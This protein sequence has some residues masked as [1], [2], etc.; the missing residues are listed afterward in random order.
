ML[1]T[2]A[3][4]ICGAIP[5]CKYL[6]R[7]AKKLYASGSPLDNALVDQWVNWACTTLMPNLDQVMLGV[8]GHEVY[9]SSWKEALKELKSNVKTID[10]ALERGKG[11]L[12]ADQMTL[13][14]VVLSI[15]LTQGFQT[16]LDKGYR[17][18]IKQATE[19][20]TKLYAKPEFVKVQGAITFCDKPLKPVTVP[21]AK[22]ESKEKKDN[23]KEAK[24]AAP[25]AQAKPDKPEKVKDNVESLPPTSFDLFNFKTLYVNHKDK[26]GAGVDTFYEM[27]DW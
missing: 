25:A 19:W 23:K 9:D 17:N 6:C 12:V 21:D 20:S 7:S 15:A 26:K 14:D 8:Y 22:V 13:A 10:N 4:N 27:L 11:W 24:K 1:E 2:D 5:V 16:E 18:A 3:G